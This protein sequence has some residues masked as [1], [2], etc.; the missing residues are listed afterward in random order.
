M[1]LYITNEL[2]STNKTYVR[3][4]IIE[5]NFMHFPRELSSRYQ[6]VNLYLKNEQGQLVGGLVSE[7]CFNWLEISYLFV[8]EAYRKLGYG[9]KMMNEAEI[10]AKEKKC[11]FIKVDT[12]SFQALDFYKKLGYEVY[13]TINNAGGYTHYYLKKDL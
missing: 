12:L 5:F 3:D 10:I 4:K 1:D 13:G 9:L 6:E 7:I 2:N 11:D 8:E